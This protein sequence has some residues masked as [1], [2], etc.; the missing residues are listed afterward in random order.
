VGGGNEVARDAEVVRE[1]KLCVTARNNAG[2]ARAVLLNDS[3]AGVHTIGCN[4]S[5]FYYSSFEITPLTAHVECLNI[6]FL[7]ANI[8]AF[9]SLKLSSARRFIGVYV[10]AWEANLCYSVLQYVFLL[11]ITYFCKHISFLT[12]VCLKDINGTD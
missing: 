1:G 10:V 5:V 12:Q 11:E 6:W 2:D 8:R 7:S 4:L 9:H 3:Q